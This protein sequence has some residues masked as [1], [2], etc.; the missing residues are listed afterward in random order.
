MPR[1]HVQCAHGAPT[2]RMGIVTHN[3]LRRPGQPGQE[4]EE[5]GGPEGE[6]AQGEGQ[7]GEAADFDEEGRRLYNLDPES[8]CV[9][10][11]CGVT[12]VCVRVGACA[13]V[14]R[15]WVCEALAGTHMC[16]AAHGANSALTRTPHAAH[17][18]AQAAAHRQGVAAAEGQVRG[19]GSS[20]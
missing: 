14:A 18:A 17:A 1:T 10:G 5:W 20:S 13:C 12:R 2:R 7:D 3:P 11:V 9:C 4:D 15:G 8:W 19:L 16:T 6:G